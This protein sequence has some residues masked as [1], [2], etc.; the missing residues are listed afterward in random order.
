MAEPLFGISVSIGIG[1]AIGV[2]RG[3]EPVHRPGQDQLVQKRCR[4]GHSAC[5]AAAVA[6]A[7]TGAAAAGTATGAVAAGAAVASA[8]G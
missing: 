2:V 1:I 5:T 7:A 6:G 8:E 4:C 3:P